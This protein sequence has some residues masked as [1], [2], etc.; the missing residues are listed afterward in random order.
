MNNENLNTEEPKPCPLSTRRNF[1]DLTGQEFDNLTV[2]YYTG[3]KQYS[4]RNRNFW[5]CQCKCGNKLEV[6]TES[7]INGLVKS[8]NCMLYSNSETRVCNKCNREKPATS[9]FFPRRPTKHKGLRGTCKDCYNAKN[10]Q[11]YRA[12][13]D[14]I[15]AQDLS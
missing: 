7:L 8:C 3:L 2:L 9:E 6:L 11:K 13:R 5:Y 1:R 15:N 10:R 12:D 14:T 4:G